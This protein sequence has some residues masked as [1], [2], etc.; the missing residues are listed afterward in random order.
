MVKNKHVEQL[1]K[2]SKKDK[3]LKNADREKAK[4]LVE[5]GCRN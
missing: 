4:K 5:G 3:S 2:I 1:V